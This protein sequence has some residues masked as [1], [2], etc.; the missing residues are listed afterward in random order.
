MNNLEFLQVKVVALA[1]A[2]AERARAGETLGLPADN[3]HPSEIAFMLANVILLL[4][5]QEDGTGSR[6]R[7]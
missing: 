7:S 3:T 5:P 1:V 4:K 2:N 6:P